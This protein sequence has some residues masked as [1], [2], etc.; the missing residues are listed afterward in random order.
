[1]G[2]PPGDSAQSPGDSARPATG[3]G[4]VDEAVA[5]LA[6][7]AELPVAEH[8]AV[9]EYVHERL[10]EALGDLDVR[11]QARPGGQ[12]PSQGP[13]QGQAQRQWP[14]QGPRPGPPP[15]RPGG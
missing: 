14:G 5:R 12:G 3:D 1:M 9:F 11:D 13:S 7:L 6:D 2:L 15:G 4:R 8:P 10:T